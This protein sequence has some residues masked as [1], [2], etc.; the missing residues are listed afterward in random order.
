MRNIGIIGYGN[1]GEA[2]IRG[3]RKKLPSFGINLIEKVE[4]RRNLA[5]KR[6]KAKDFGE[7][8]KALLDESEVVILAVKP[9][10]IDVIMKAIGPFTKGSRLISI[11]AGKQISYFKQF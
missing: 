7:D 1:M 3:I 5:I 2:M 11:L 9:Q 4:V 8:Y 6:V 10:D